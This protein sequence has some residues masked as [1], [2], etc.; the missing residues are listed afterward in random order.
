MHIVSGDGDGM[1]LHSC[2]GLGY[3][4][5]VS[6]VDGTQHPFVRRMCRSPSAA[7]IG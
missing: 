7:N 3:I 2:P 4:A 1:Q 5:S 6:I